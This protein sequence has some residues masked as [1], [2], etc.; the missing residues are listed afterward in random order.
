MRIDKSGNV[1]IGTSAPKGAL[2]VNGDYY[3]SGHLFLHAV[4]GDGSS[5][6]AFVQAR[7]DSGTSSIGLTLRT[8]NGGSLVNAASFTSAGAFTVVGS[9]F[10]PGGGSWAATSDRRLKKNI[11]PLTGALDRLMEL[12]SVTFQYKDP[13]VSGY[14]PGTQTGFIAQEVEPHFPDWVKT[15]EDGMKILSIT[16]FESLTVQALRELREEKDAEMKAKD[17]KIADLE[18]RLAKLEQMMLGGGAAEKTLVSTKKE[19]RP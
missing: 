5:G 8:Q 16:G 15:G 4:E 12:R 6:T 14:A 2:H 1:G 18:A 17:E 11:E 10:K 7:D 9:A 13:K 19:A 3:G